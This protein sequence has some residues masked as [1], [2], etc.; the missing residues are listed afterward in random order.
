M[1][2]AWLPSMQPDWKGQVEADLAASGLTLLPHRSSL[3]H[4]YLNF[5]LMPKAVLQLNPILLLLQLLL[6]LQQL[7]VQA[8]VLQVAQVAQVASSRSPAW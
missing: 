1:L 5:L 4:Q 7:L 8:L 6:H 3:L 2:Q